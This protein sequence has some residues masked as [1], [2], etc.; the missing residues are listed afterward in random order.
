MSNIDKTLL[1]EKKRYENL[2][3]EIATSLS[4]KYLYTNNDDNKNSWWLEPVDVLQH[5]LDFTR[6]H[7]HAE[8]CALFLVDSSKK[9]LVLE[10]I[11]GD[12]NFNKIK[13][14]ATYDLASASDAQGAR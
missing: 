3:A 12:V 13:D 8:K 1:K 7:L 14:V 10:R 5:L 6:N 2:F 4:D 9:S 11:S